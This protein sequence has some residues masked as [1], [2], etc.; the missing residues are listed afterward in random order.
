MTIFLGR[1]AE[2]RALGHY[3]SAVRDGENAAG[4][5][6]LVSGPR[7]VGKTRL[8]GEFLRR[9][10]TRALV[11]TPPE[12]AGA[13]SADEHIA[14]FAARAASSPLLHAERFRDILA[15]DWD[16]ALRLLAD[17][18]GDEPTVAVF[19]NVEDIVTADREF[20]AA[21]RRSWERHLG[22]RP[23][24]VIL[25][26]RDVAVLAGAVP[27]ATV[28][29]LEPFNPAELGHILGVDA[30]AAFDAHLVTGGH[31]DIVAEWPTGAGAL[32][33]V[34]S[35]LARSP[36]GFEVRAELT[37]AR[38]FGLDS[39]PVALLRA[40]GPGESSRAAIGKVAGLPPASVD[41]GLT[42]LAATGYLAVDRPRSL[43]A[44]R[45]ARYRLADPYLRLW[46]TTVAAHRAELDRGE[47]DAVMVAIR[48]RWPAWRRGAM[49]LVVRGA[50][51][52]LAAL[53]QLPGTGAVGG[54]WTRFDDVH[55]DLVGTDRDDNPGAV[56][57]VGTCQWD[58]AP[59][60][61]YALAS[62]IAVRDKVPGVAP[63]TPLVAV[64]LAGSTVGDAVAAVLGPDELITAWTA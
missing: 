7:G 24:L 50:M 8:I 17:A 11:F 60:D 16:T 29:P 43:R 32:D 42:R 44:S 19:D 5:I 51:H 4:G 61:H 22:A 53:G 34:E 39:Q 33:A 9:S 54:Y 28:L 25:L 10:R 2:L 45:E 63:T 64:S 46:M 55:V 35:M 30:A 6:V 1:L 27:D 59:F 56:T 40:T 36:S 38:E 49:E 48:D 20:P 62:L 18:A 3:E 37:L 14:A 13:R 57:F 31:P 21:L 26:V 23:V 41:R 15:P 47:T 58:D 12:A 52:R